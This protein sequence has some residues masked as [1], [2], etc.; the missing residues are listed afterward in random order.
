[1][2]A[3]KAFVTSRGR[4]MWGCL[5]H[6]SLCLGLSNAVSPKLCLSSLLHCFFALYVPPLVPLRVSL[7]HFPLSDDSGGW[8]RGGGEISGDYHCLENTDGFVRHLRS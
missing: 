3:Q 2:A 8:K 4:V 6:I 5:I 1:M 7:L